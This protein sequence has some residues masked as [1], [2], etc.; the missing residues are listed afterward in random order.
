MNRAGV[1]DVRVL[2]GEP[3]TVPGQTVMAAHDRQPRAAPREVQRQEKVS[4]RAIRWQGEA[5]LSKGFAA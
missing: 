5:R 2:L 3:A 4:L 1:T